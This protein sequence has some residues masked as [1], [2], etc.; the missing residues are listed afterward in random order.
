M[1]L[2]EKTLASEAGARVA[3]ECRP[4]GLR[5]TMDIPLAADVLK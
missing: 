2:I 4:E 3:V 5:C 1:R